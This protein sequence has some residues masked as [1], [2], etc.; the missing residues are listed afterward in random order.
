M[1]LATRGLGVALGGRT[2]LDRLDLALG[3]ASVTGLIGPNGAGKTTL[4]RA[5]A[6]V[7]P[8]SCGSV[9]LDQ[10]SVAAWRR[11]A[12]ARTIAYL[13]QGAP[14]A[15][16]MTVRRVVALGRLPH[17]S[18]WRGP[19][20]DDARAIDAALAA[21]DVVH[22][23]D[24]NV[25]TLSGGERARVMLARALAVGPRY[26]LA[27]E[28]VAGL[29]PEHQLQVMTL[30]RQRATAGAGIVVTLHDLSLAARFCDRLVVLDHGRIAADGAPDAVLTPSVL[31]SVFAVSAACG[32]RD[33]Q[34]F[35]VPWKV[36]PRLRDVGSERGRGEAGD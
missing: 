28:P 6:G 10:R 16:P 19:A 17:L 9:T 32:R 29:D 21:T 11:D 27:D 31:A 15:W 2:I 20:A 36:V 24:R 1:T 3:A 14:C 33:G 22:L 23:A 5:I 35:V 34:P 30:L 26:L 4:L 18:P 7:V 25:L 8:L 12:L 13:P